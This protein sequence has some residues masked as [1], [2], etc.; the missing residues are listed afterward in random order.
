MSEHLTVINKKLDELVHRTLAGMAHWSG[1][2]PKGA[3][4]GE[5]KYLATIN[6]KPLRCMKYTRLM[7]GKIGPKAIP[8]NT[9]ACKYFEPEKTGA[10]E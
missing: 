6:R 9:K 4:C 10:S 5:C 2:G 7:S 1:T 3:R 8:L